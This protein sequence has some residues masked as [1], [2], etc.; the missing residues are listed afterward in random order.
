MPVTVTVTVMCVCMYTVN[1]PLDINHA[2][3]MTVAT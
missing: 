2:V 3:S 1:F